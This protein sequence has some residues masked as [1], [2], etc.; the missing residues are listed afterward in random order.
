[1]CLE[2]AAQVRSRQEQLQLQQLEDK[3]VHELLESGRR[4]EEEREAQRVQRQRQRS[5]QQLDFIR[6]QMEE[7]EQQRQQLRQQRQEEATL[8]VCIH[9]ST[10]DGFMVTFKDH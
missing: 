6:T 5:L 7:A 2:Q 9:A 3:M 8:M 10:A 1:M 4:A